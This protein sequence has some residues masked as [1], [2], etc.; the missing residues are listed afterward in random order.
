MLFSQDFRLS[1]NKLCHNH[2]AARKLCQWDSE[3]TKEDKGTKG[4]A[5][6]KPSADQEE[7]AAELLL[8]SKTAEKKEQEDDSEI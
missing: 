4:A 2:H 3:R 5:N 8:Q 7:R 6:A 1:G